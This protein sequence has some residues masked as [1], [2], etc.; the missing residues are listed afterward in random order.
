MLREGEGLIWSRSSFLGKISGKNFPSA[1]LKSQSSQ[2]KPRKAIQRKGPGEKSN[3]FFQ[4]ERGN[5]RQGCSRSKVKKKKILR[6]MVTH[7]EIPLCCPTYLKQ[8][9]ESLL[10]SSVL[11]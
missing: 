7:G 2:A 8:E 4:R 10:A 5:L 11:V 3:F 1:P 6:M 9:I